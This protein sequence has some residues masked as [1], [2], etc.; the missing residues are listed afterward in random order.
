MLILK[1][2][3]SEKIIEYCDKEFPDETCGILA[4]KRDKIEMAY[5]MKNMD[6]SP[7]SYFM[8]PKEQLKAMKDIREQGLEMLAIYHSHTFSQAYP[9]A[10]DIE[11][12]F[13][14]DVSYMI[15]SLAD[16]KTPV[17]RSFKIQGGDIREE[18]VRIE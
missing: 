8:D 5:S 4:G 12:A 10:K 9:S 7:M 2:D 17:L 14:P 13:Y 15:I 16:K 18:E 11:L 6:K 1:K 3:L